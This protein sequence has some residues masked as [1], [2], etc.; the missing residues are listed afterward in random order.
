MAA[1]DTLSLPE[2][3]WYTW[4]PM[5]LL[6]DAIAHSWLSM[7]HADA[8]PTL[9]A[10][11]ALLASCHSLSTWVCLQLLQHSAL[12]S[13]LG[14]CSARAPEM[15]VLAAA[16]WLP[17]TGSCAKAALQGVCTEERGCLVS[18]DAAHMWLALPCYTAAPG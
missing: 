7:L 8:L 5:L 3:E 12:V 1:Y 13:A 18:A 2:A 4:P 10:L 14:H 9:H 15:E 6:L 16:R 11:R 17:I